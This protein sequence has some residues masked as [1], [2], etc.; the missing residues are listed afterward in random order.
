MSAKPR[1]LDA[2]TL[3]SIPLARERLSVGRRRVDA[4]HVTVKTITDVEPVAIDETLRADHVSIERTPVGRFVEE[5]PAPRYDGDT[6]IIPVVEEVLVVERRLRLV[7]EVRIERQVTTRQHRET[8]P[9]RRQRL[10]V[11]RRPVAGARGNRSKS[12]ISRKM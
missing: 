10:E 11:T 3:R 8:V 2:P 9:V 12:A 4:G 1:P 5:P 7:E 6:L